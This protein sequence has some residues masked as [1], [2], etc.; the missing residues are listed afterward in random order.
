MKSVLIFGISGF[1]GNYL[2][3]EFFEFGYKVFG[4]DKVKSETLPKFVEFIEADLLDAEAVGSIVEATKPN[5]IVNLAAISS[6]GASWNIPIVTM[7]VNVGGSLNIL[8]AVRKFAPN[9]KVLFVGSSEEYESSDAPIPETAPL[10][11]NNPYGISK[12]SQEQFAK[13][14]SEHYGLKIYSV[15]SFNHTGV[16]QK[17]TFVLP[18]F[19]KQVA[20][21]EKSG[22]PGIIKVGNIDVRRDFSDVRDVARAYRLVLE[23]E[24]NLETYNVGSG[25]SYSIAE[26]LKYIISLGHQKIIVTPDPLKIRP[27]D[28][29]SI[30]CD[31][32]K[33]K[34]KLNWSPNYS[35][36][37][38]INDIF[39]YYLKA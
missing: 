37:E 26:L 9:T 18:S 12:I 24:N 14:Y 8:E 1:V 2:A 7:R 5:S 34:E 23:S 30:V 11:A 36:Y 33:I 20:E 17:D 19:C 28:T 25:N 22:K 29:A 15:R 39:C 6:V 27:T 10:N 38:T 32:T 35:I 21:I 3:K 13:I 4:S 16:G 31:N